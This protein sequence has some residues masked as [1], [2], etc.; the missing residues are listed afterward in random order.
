M[1]NTVTR[2]KWKINDTI[3]HIASGHPYL[4]IHISRYSC[5]VIDLH[6]HDSP[7]PSL[8]ILPRNYHEYASDNELTLKKN[9]SFCY[10]Q[11]TL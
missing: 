10:T 7:I 4:V 2:V 9:G 3:R 8:T 1:E 11:M 5:L 6:S